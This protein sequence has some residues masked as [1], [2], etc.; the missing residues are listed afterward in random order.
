MKHLLSRSSKLVILEIPLP[1][2]RNYI[3]SCELV[4][5]SL[6]FCKRGTR[7]PCPMAIQDGLVSRPLRPLLAR[8][9]CPSLLH[10]SLDVCF[11]SCSTCTEE[12]P[13]A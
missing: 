13:E 12:L 5:F 9:G 8:P 11:R 4:A 10:W 1:R 2:E 6:A 7:A 3:S